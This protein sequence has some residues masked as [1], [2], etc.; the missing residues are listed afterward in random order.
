MDYTTT[1]YKDIDL[2]NFGSEL[3]EDRIVT[4]TKVVRHQIVRNIVAL[5]GVQVAN[6]LFPLII[7]PYV[8]RV[9][10]PEGWGMVVFAQSL[11]MWLSLVIEY[12]FGLSATREIARKRDDN[13]YLIQIA[14]GVLGAKCVLSFG[15]IFVS[16]IIFWTVPILQQFPEYLLLAWLS[17]FTQGLNPLWYFQGTER[18]QLP[19]TLNIGAR[20]LV[21]VLIFFMVQGPNDGKL[22]LAL[23]LI[24]DLLTTGISIIWMY[25]EISFKWPKLE[26]TL[27]ALR[28]GWSM[29]FFRSAV[30]LYTTANGFILGLFVPPALVGFYGGAEKIN[31]AILAMLNPISQVLYPRMNYLV[32]RDGRRAS[33][34]AYISLLLMGGIGVFLGGIV[35][36]CAPLIISILF[37]P[38]YEP[39]TRVL[40]VLAFIIPLIALSNVLGIQWMLPLGLDRL[41]NSIILIAG[42]I[43]IGLAIFLAPRF[44]PLGMAWAVVVSEAFVTFS[45]F[46]TLWMKRLVPYGGLK[47]EG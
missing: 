47:H 22:L 29:F 21:T 17:A 14:A 19:A 39:S 25:R 42:F 18:L 10:R 8:S 38:G 24:A 5:Y 33:N 23:Q 1:Q 7:I 27:S 28:S 30:S 16:I 15:T 20:F 35:F 46:I 43:N 32:A 44:G 11:A 6:Y 9:L 45:Q 37:G 31:K 3:M 2:L 13:N 12:G 40:R 41:F 34:M 4:I 36:I 26:E